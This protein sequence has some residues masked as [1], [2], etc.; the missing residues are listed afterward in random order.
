MYFELK[1]VISDG[2]RTATKRN[3]NEENVQIAHKKKVIKDTSKN[4][5]VVLK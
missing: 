1:R 3:L 2:Y 4:L 5:K